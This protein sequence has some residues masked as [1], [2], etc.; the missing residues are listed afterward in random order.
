[1]AVHFDFV[2]DDADAE[3]IMDAIRAQSSKCNERI[4]ER[5]GTSSHPAEILALQNQKR[6][7]QGLI[8]KMKN[9]RV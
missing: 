2:V 9:T 4:M 6:Y 5:Q 7:W 8:P 1:M 3:N